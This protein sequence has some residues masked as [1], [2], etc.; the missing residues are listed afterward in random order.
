MVYGEISRY[1]TIYNDNASGSKQTNSSFHK[2]CIDR[3][4]TFIFKTYVL[5]QYYMFS[6][7]EF[8]IAKGKN[9]FESGN[10]H[11]CNFVLGILKGN[12]HSSMKNKLN[13]VEVNLIDQTSL[14]CIKN[15]SVEYAKCSCAVG[16]T[17]CSHM[18]ALL[19][20]AH[21]HILVT[22]LNALG[23]KKENLMMIL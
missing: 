5:K 15:N 11:S 23:K 22:T 20:H 2:K 6:M 21:K 3:R 4:F 9:H 14:I 13:D 7:L 18:M 12:V 10:V 17:K 8:I 16:Q 19:L 1:V